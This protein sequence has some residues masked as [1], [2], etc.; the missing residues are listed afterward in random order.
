LLRSTRPRKRCSPK[1]QN[2]GRLLFGGGVR[3]K[4]GVFCSNVCRNNVAHPGFCNA[5][6]AASAP[7]PAGGNVT[8]NGVGSTF[9]GSSDPCKTCGSVVQTQWFCF[10]FIPLARLGKFRVKYVAPNR[11]L[12]RMAR[13]ESEWQAIA[14]ALRKAGWTWGCTSRVDSNGRTVFV[15]DA[16]RDGKR[17]VLR[18]DES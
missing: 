5:C 16:Q 14:D 6:I 10:F 11:Y 13:R 1:C 15:A 17:F 8:V 12:S 9:Y 4:L 7:T 2:C 3:D 18:A